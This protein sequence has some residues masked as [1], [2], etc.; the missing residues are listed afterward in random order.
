MW[1]VGRAGLMLVF[2]AA[3]LAAEAP[4][5]AAANAVVRQ[6]PPAEAPSRGVLHLAVDTPPGEAVTPVPIEGAGQVERGVVYDF[7][8]IEQLAARAA[9]A[10]GRPIDPGAPPPALLE[11]RLTAVAYRILCGAG[12]A[13]P[14]AVSLF[15]VDGQL[16]PAEGAPMVGDLLSQALPGATIPVGSLGKTFGK[17]YLS[18]GDTIRITYD[19]GC[20]GGNAYT[21]PA[22]VMAV[23]RVTHRVDLPP[24]TPPLG[25]PAQVR[26]EAIVAGDGKARYASM[27]AG[28]K[29][30]ESRVLETISQWTFEPGR[31]NGV[32]VPFTFETTFALR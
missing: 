26:V 24:G 5:M 22:I 18:S 23:P 28:P 8:R 32:I 2:L 27:L 16:V 1:Q 10:A 15:D 25:K 20:Q 29:E 7:F 9:V 11:G 21:S 19:D 12:S 31:T 30:L 17:Q 4:T 14:V 6:T 3:P 13:A